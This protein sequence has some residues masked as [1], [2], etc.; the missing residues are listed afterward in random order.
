MEEIVYDTNEL[1]DAAKKSKQ[2]LTG[3][4]TILNLASFPRHWNSRA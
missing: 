1:I 3:F 4:T 2:M